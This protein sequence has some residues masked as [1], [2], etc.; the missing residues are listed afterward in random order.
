MILKIK[1]LITLSTRQ[2]KFKRKSLLQKKLFNPIKGKKVKI[3]IILAILIHHPLN[4]NNQNPFNNKKI[5]RDVQSKK[6]NQNLFKIQIRFHKLNPYKK[7]KQENL[8]FLNK[9]SLK[10]IKVSMEKMIRKNILMFMKEVIEIL[11][12]S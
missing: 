10:K 4:Q 8:Q 12:N 3:F 5:M 2:R 11:S 6:H 9:I 7:K 1:K